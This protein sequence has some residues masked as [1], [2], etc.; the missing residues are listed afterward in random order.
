MPYVILSG[1]VTFALMAHCFKTGRERYWLYILFIAPGLGAAAYIV[2]ELLPDFFRSLTG[3]KITRKVKASINPEGELKKR[4]QDFAR[5]QSAASTHRLAEELMERKDYAEAEKL[6]SESRKGLFEFDPVLM[7]GQATALFKL[8]RYDETVEI[9]DKLIN[10]VPDYRSQDG[11]LLYARA[12]AEAGHR[13]KALEE[14]NVLVDYFSGPEARIRYAEF[15]VK[16]QD[17]DGARRQC[18]QVL[19]TAELS[20]RHYRKTHKKW[21]SRAKAM[22]K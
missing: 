4:S 18:E 15:L 12:H 3:R 7:Q 1:L 14:F 5:S 10:E 17:H 9:M 8:E 11:H 6:Y 20:P 2:I 16:E 13:D 21:I 19:E 22:L